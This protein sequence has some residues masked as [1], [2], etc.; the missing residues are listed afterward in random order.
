MSAGAGKIAGVAVA[1][2]LLFACSATAVSMRAPERASA[3]P[4]KYVV[5]VLA[6]F[7][8]LL[9]VHDVGVRRT[10]VTRVLFGMRP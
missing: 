7:V 2:A 8:V 3:A 6:S 9:A 1:A 5:V 10:R 4:A